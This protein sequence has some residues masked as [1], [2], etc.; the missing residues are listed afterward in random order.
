VNRQE[1][2]QLTA[3]DGARFPV[4]LHWDDAVPQKTAFLIMHPTGDWQNHF[5]LPHLVARGFGALGCA[6]RY[7]SHEA[8]L[9][10]E[11]TLL[12]WGACVDHL[13]AKGY[14]KVIGI[15][16]S[17]G[18]EI[19]SGYQA[20][21]VR[22]T[23][24]GTPTGD[25][26]DFT[27]IKLAPLDGI[28]FLNSHMGRPQSLTQSLDPSVGGESGNDP[29]DYDASLD[30]YNPA[31]GPPYVPAFVTRYRAAQIERNHKITR[32]CRDAIAK[33]RATGNPLLHDVTF[34]VHRTDASLLLL[35]KSLDPSDR[36]GLTIWDENPRIANYTPGPQRG[37]RVRLR[38]ITAKAWLSQRSLDASQFDVTRFLA[39]CA[40]PTVILIGTADAIGTEHSRR[41]FE[42][43]PDPGKTLVR[44]KDGTHFM[45]GQE[46]KQAEA[47]DHIAAF[48][49]AR[50]LA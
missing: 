21:A 41:I 34:I 49:R 11:H 43:S 1:Q 2:A 39:D 38:V 26:P 30:M 15:G 46:D 50:G 12:D 22:P 17:G 8:E 32:W 5:M 44:I 19:V 24:T 7:S 25:P 9:L 4:T 13:R 23:L 6:N 31:N 45:R 28:V 3:Q 16:N 35:D 37:N 20:Q 27:K 18:G 40:V 10:L 36:T 47:A 48:V 29:F 14:R 42:A 33:V